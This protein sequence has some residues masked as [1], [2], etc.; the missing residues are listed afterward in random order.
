MIGSQKNG[1]C[2]MSICKIISYVKRSMVNMPITGQ[3]CALGNTGNWENL[4]EM[5]LH[6]KM[7][8]CYKF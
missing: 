4:N 6:Y 3:A 1:C 5:P 8:F 2:K 7:L